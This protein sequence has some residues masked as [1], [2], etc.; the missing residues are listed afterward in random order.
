[1]ADYKFI[2]WLNEE[3]KDPS[4]LGG[5]GANLNKLILMGIPVP[6]GFV[7]TTEAFNYF[8]TVNGLRDRVLNIINEVVKEGRPEEY[9]EAERRIKELILNTDIPKDLYDEISRAYMELSKSFNTDAIAVAVRSSASAEDLWTAS[10]AGQQD[11]YL[12]VR[13][14]T[15]DLIRYVKYVWASTYNAR[16]LAYRDEKDIPH[17]VAYMAVI[18]QKLVNSKAAGV[19]F[20]INPVTGDNNEVVIEA[21]WGGLGGRR[22]LVVW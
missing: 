6:P 20:T 13:G 11:T 19:M 1:M 9:E 8:M 4:I 17:D 21:S 7:I 16:A 2:V 10:F 14:G 12:N 18:V 15:E 3:V 22:W 5:K